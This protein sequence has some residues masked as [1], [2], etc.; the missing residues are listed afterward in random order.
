MAAPTRT[1]R[2]KPAPRRRRNTRRRAPA[3]LR[4]GLGIV[5]VMLAVVGL[6]HL[7]GGSPPVDPTDGLRNAGG[8]LGAAVSSPLAA[9]AG[10]VGTA[11]ILTGLGLLG[12]LLAPGVP[13]RRVFDAIAAAARW[14]TA[15]V[16]ELFQLRGHDPGEAALDEPEPAA[17]VA[18]LDELDEDDIDLDDVP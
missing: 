6:L 11:V 13:M 3:P 12:L 7:A 9:G 5:L 8:L 17:S 1:R 10:V 14:V 2:R 18:A 16:S 15:A 4:I